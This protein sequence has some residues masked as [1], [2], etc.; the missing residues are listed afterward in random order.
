MGPPVVLA[1][2]LGR[3]DICAVTALDDRIGVIWS[4]QKRQAVRFRTHDPNAP[5]S[6]WAPAV[7]V[8]EGNH[9]ADDHVNLC[10][11][12]AAGA[13]RLLAVTKTSLD[14]VGE[15]IFSLRVLAAAGGW[16]SVPFGPLT[17]REDLTR[18]IVVWHGGRPI[19][20]YTSRNRGRGGGVNPFSVI[21]L[22]A[23][24]PDASGTAGPP[25]VVIRAADRVNNATGPKTAP[26]D[27]A[28][29]VL[30]SSAAGGVYEALV[31]LED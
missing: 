6:V 18:P 4:D 7:T 15:P 27:A 30:A 26:D 19:V 22:Q 11:P 21:S 13:P 29:L 16:R 10:R 3:D 1:T 14:T 23:F 5:D 17:Q 31:E 24:V 20:L 25:R 2:G 28:C 9:T 8:A 12:R